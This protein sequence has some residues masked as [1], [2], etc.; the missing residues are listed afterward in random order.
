MYVRVL[1][2]YL[3]T[4]WMKYL[5]VSWTRNT[6]IT[7]QSG[8]GKAHMMTSSLHKELQRTNEH[9]ELD[10]L[11]SPE[12]RKPIVYA[13]PNNHPWK[14]TSNSIKMEQVILKNTIYMH[15][16]TYMHAA[17]TN[18][19]RSQWFKNNREGY[20]KSWKEEGKG[21]NTVI[22]ISKIKK[23]KKYSGC[24]DR[25]MAI[26]KNYY[27][28]I[29]PSFFSDKTMSISNSRQ[30]FYFL[31]LYDIQLNGSHLKQKSVD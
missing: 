27:N 29:L 21:I 10:K 2:S 3:K 19:K 20:L 18:E 11:S 13:I 4:K 7:G 26:Q 22:T 8:Q 12:M 1:I 5:S 28:S 17:S 31:T 24:I 16:H 14:H 6:P 25:N 9:W 30:E 23:E 15:K